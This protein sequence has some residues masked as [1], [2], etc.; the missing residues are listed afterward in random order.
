MPEVLSPREHKDW[1]PRLELVG[2]S[3]RALINEDVTGLRWITIV[4]DIR[5]LIDFNSAI[6]REE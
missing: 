1:K 2:Y 6:L 3:L 4:N 5:T